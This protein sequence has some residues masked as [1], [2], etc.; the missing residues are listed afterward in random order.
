[1]T[2][3]FT[4]SE[5]NSTFACRFD[6]AATA[7]PCTSPMTYAGLAEGAHKF[8]VKATDP[9]GNTDPTA[10]R[11]TFTVDTTPPETTITS[12]PSGTITQSDAS[13]SFS[14]SEAGSHFRCRLDSASFEGCNSL[15]AYSSLAAGTHRFRVRAIDRAG[16]LDPTPAIR[17]FT[18]QP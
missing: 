12:G 7:T 14:A 15:K 17:D 4:S 3:G 1:V 8:R 5:A 18:V 13:F 6:S 2:F 11:R 16:N 9:A 10:A